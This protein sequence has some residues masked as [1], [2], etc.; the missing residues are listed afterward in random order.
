MATGKRA[1][2]VD[3][4]NRDRAL[5]ALQRRSSGAAGVHR[6]ARFPNRG[7]ARRTAIRASREA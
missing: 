5:W 3:G 4:G 2:T 7:Q 1:V 6:Q